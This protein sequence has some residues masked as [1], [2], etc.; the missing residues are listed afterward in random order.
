[1]QLVLPP[2]ARDTKETAFAIWQLGTALEPIN[3][4]QTRDK[5]AL[6]GDEPAPPH[7]LGKVFVQATRSDAQDLVFSDNPQ[8]PHHPSPLRQETLLP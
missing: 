1:M 6:V 4:P 8:P 7:P 2:L 5:I 3:T